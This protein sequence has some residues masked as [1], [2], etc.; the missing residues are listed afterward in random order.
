MLEGYLNQTTKSMPDL[1]QQANALAKE[2][3]D[4]A[5][6]GQENGPVPTPAPADP[7]STDT[8]P[9][10]TR[11]PTPTENGNERLQTQELPDR[12]DVRD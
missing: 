4:S 5:T 9:T 8:T 7:G 12:T 10:P 3:I 11:L 2:V 1:Q 6:T